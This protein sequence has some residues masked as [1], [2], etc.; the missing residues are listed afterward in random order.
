MSYIKAYTKEKYKAENEEITERFEELK[1]TNTY[2]CNNIFECECS[3]KL[4]YRNKAAH[5]KIPKHQEYVKR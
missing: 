3:S 4:I 2:K 1:M 5:F